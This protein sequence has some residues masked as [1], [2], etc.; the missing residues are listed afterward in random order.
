MRQKPVIRMLAQTPVI[1]VLAALAIALSVPASASVHTVDDSGGADFTTIGEAIAAS[2]DGDTV[3]VHAGTYTGAQNRGLSLDYKNL[4]IFADDG[5]MMTTIDCEGQDRAFLLNTGQDTTTVI[6][7]FSIV[8]G[9][10]LALGI[11]SGGAIYMH[12]GS[13]AVIADCAFTGN[14]ATDGGAISI[15]SGNSPRI[16]NCYFF[17]NSATLFGGAVNCNYDASVIRGCGFSGNTAPSGGAVRVYYSSTAI[18]DCT[19]SGANAATDSGGAVWYGECPTGSPLDGCAFTANGAAYGGAV[20]I[21]ASAPR[22]T[23]CVF[24]FNDA[25]EQGGGLMAGAGDRLTMTG[26]EFYGNTA[27]YG[28]GASVAGER[29]LMG[30]CAF[31][32]NEADQLGGA[33]YASVD[34]FSVTDCAF[35]DNYAGGQGGGAVGVSG[36]SFSSRL[37]S[38]TFA[39]NYTDGNGGAVHWAD[40]GGGL[41]GCTFYRN[42]AYGDGGA[43][44]TWGAPSPQILSCTFSENET[45]AGQGGGIYDDTDGAIIA[46][47]IVAFSAVG[48]GIVSTGPDPEIFHCCVFANAGGDSLPGTHY[49]N[50]FTDPLFCDAAGDD[51]TLCADSPCLPANNAWSTLIGAHGQGCPGC[52]TAVETQSWGRIKALYR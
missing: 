10:A 16:R 12:T 34:T 8:N 24:T 18:V 3:M 29:L 43:L 50:M 32:S 14:T 38:S 35:T 51:Y 21:T 2:S 46:N 25:V 52:D 48:A 9:N 47:T 6:L 36:A 26:C 17:D 27:G 1:E 7:G 30:G 4:T 28:A 40:G 44:Y 37:E 19:F 23:E 5:Y 42:T 13:E 41:D 22:I 49:E 31:V 20:Y 15:G 39:G 11:T 45:A 33:V